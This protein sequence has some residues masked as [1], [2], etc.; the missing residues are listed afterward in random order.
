M[1]DD[2]IQGAVA[3]EQKFDDNP[4]SLPLEEINILKDKEKT[5]SLEPSLWHKSQHF[6]FC[7]F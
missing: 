3:N 7:F 5:N 1:S 2:L 4:Y 6:P